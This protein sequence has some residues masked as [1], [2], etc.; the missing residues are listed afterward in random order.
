[1]YLSSTGPMVK[2]FFLFQL[3]LIRMDIVSLHI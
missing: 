2:R 3:A 1:V